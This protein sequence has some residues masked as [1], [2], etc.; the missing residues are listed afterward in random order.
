MSWTCDLLQC[1]RDLRLR[2]GMGA[3]M[4]VV[5]L[6]RLGFAQRL[7]CL[8]FELRQ[9][10]LCYVLGEEFWCDLIVLKLVLLMDLR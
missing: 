2:H 9:R 5:C 4:R 6:L 7:V 8:C 1:E 10:R 3:G